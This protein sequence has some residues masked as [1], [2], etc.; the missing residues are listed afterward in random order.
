[1]PEYRA[2]FYCLFGAFFCLGG[3]WIAMPEL[4][5]ALKTWELDVLT[6]PRNKTHEHLV[7]NDTPLKFILYLSRDFASSIAFLIA[8]LGMCW[9]MVRGP[10]A[11]KGWGSRLGF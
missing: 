3:A 10:K 4:F 1:M 11:F 6:G 2:K 5:D 9:R 7:Y 8:G